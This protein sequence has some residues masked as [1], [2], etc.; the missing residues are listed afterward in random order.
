[1]RKDPR[2]KLV[3]KSPMRNLTGKWYLKK[4]WF[5]YTIMVEVERRNGCDH[6]FTFGPEYKTW[7]KATDAD[8]IELQDKITII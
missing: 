5:G 3:I 2:H 1:M 7:E 8:L 4:K 6:D